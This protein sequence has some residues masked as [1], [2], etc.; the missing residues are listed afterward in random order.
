MALETIEIRLTKGLLKAIDRMIEQ[1]L[2]LNRSE[3]IRDAIRKQFFLR[4]VEKI[5]ENKNY[6]SYRKKDNIKPE[7]Y[8]SRRKEKIEQINSVF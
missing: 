4:S 2:Y 7:S 6:I 1:G 3:A 5:S 8:S